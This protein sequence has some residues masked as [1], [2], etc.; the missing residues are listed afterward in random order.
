M[1]EIIYSIL[2]ILLTIVLFGVTL[3]VYL[4]LSLKDGRN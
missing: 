4:W 2:I 3:V 1:I